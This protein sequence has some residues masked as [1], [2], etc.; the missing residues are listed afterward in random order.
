M[1]EGHAAGS[2]PQ[3]HGHDDEQG[4]LHDHGWKQN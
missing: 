2:A 1:S 4:V 3:V